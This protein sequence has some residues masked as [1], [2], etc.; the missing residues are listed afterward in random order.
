MRYSRKELR[1]RLA[2]INAVLIK[3]DIKKQFQV[4]HRY[5]YYGLDVA[6]VDGRIL[7]G[8]LTTGSFRECV[9]QAQ[10]TAFDWIAQKHF[11]IEE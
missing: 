7:S 2:W 6:H 9:D 5:D 8:P 11:P 10:A 3:A 1:D 4:T